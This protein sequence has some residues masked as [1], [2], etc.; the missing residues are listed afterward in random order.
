MTVSP[1]GVTGNSA[2]H[3]RTYWSLDEPWIFLV[4]PATFKYGRTETS[5][6]TKTSSTLQECSFF[7]ILSWNS[8]SQPS[9]FFHHLVLHV[10]PSISRIENP[11]ASLWNPRYSEKGDLP[12]HFTSVFSLVMPFHQ[13]PLYFAQMPFYFTQMLFYFAQMLFY[14][15]QMPFYF[16]QMRLFFAHFCFPPPSP[17]THTPV[18]G[19]A[20]MNLV[21]CFCPCPCRSSLGVLS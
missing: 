5:E 12:E 10:C 2:F 8:A 13:M 7:R 17:H 16:A 19:A 21:P 14:F 11:R 9:I 20:A 6:T 15:A 4:G 3:C 18:P 1:S